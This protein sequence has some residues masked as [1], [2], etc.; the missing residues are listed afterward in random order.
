MAQSSLRTCFRV[1]VVL[2]LLTSVAAHAEPGDDSGDP[3]IFATVVE[4]VLELSGFAHT[5]VVDV[6]SQDD[7]ELNGC[8]MPIG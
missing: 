1:L 2:V 3:G 4:Y 6:P 7:S 8:I 5:G